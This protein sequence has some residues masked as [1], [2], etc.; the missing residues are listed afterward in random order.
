[1]SVTPQAYNA[2]FYVLANAPLYNPNVT[3]INVSL[4]SNLT[5]D[6]WCSE[7][8]PVQNL[9][10]FDYTQ[11]NAQLVNNVT[12]PNSNNT[13]AITFNA[14]EVAGS[15]FY[16]DLIS[17]FP[18]TYKNRPNGLRKDLA[19]SIKDLGTTFLRFPGGNNLEGYSIAERWKWNETIGPLRYRKGRPGTWEYINT[20]G[21]G[22]MEFLEWT[23]DMEIER[24]LAIYSGYS[25][26]IQGNEGQ[27]YPEEYMGS[28]LQEALD[29]L[30]FCMGNTS[31][32]YGALRAQYGHPEPFQIKCVS[33]MAVAGGQHLQRS[34]LYRNR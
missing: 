16:F 17:L 28:V 24:V 6:I 7:T 1:M 33:S 27:S 4:R 26:N 32:P 5:S 19:E 11:L 18:E 12:A 30:E 20:N 13:F 21:L 29:E 3:A 15:T 9:S 2:S 34:Q 14:S 23:E 8:I 25:L 10:S 31:T 22:F